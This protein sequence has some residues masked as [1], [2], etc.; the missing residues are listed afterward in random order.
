M[1]KEKLFNEFQKY[2]LDNIINFISQEM[3]E[4]FEVYFAELIEWNKFLNLISFKSEK[5]LIHRHFC[6]SLYSAKIIN[7][8]AGKNAV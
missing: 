5:D 2:A 3:K 4:K 1:E 7:E 6:D 8:I